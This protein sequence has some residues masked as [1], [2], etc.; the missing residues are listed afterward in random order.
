MTKQLAKENATIVDENADY[1][2]WYTREENKHLGAV[3]VGIGMAMN[4]GV[5]PDLPVIRLPVRDCR[6]AVVAEDK[7]D[8]KSIREDWNYGTD[9]RKPEIRVF[10]PHLVLHERTMLWLGRGPDGQLVVYD[11]DSDMKWAKIINDAHAWEW[12][13]Q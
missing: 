12:E 7:L 2:L 4:L 11:E 3:L 5:V 1:C 10:I 9:W 13:Q 8:I 6:F